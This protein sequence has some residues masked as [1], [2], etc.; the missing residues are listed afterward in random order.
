MFEMFLSNRNKHRS[1]LYGK[2]GEDMACDYLKGKG[3]K[4]IE[5]NFLCN[6]GEI[7][8]IAQKDN[9]LIFI[10]VKTRQNDRFGQG[11][12]L[13]TNEK[14]R[15]IMNASIV[16]L[17]NHLKEGVSVR[18]DLIDIMGDNLEHLEAIF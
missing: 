17:K 2:K 9:W 12:E 16:Y 13:I 1:D 6:M 7:D 10:E 5:R 3:Y 18:Y 15:K 4:I 11:K 14:K 8:I